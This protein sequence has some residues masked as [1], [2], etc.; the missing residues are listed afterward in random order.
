MT[1]RIEVNDSDRTINSNVVT[2][3]PKKIIEDVCIK[4]ENKK[5]TPEPLWHFKL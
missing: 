1:L 2:G 3:N 5:L 4:L